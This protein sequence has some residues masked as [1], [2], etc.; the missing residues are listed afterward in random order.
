M[1]VGWINKNPQNNCMSQEI[2]YLTRISKHDSWHLDQ[3]K[4]E[5]YDQSC[6]YCHKESPFQLTKEFKDFWK[7]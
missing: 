7:L 3:E 4:P 6:R 2:R 1:R 5:V